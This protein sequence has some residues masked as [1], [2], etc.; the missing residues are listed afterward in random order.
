MRGYL[1][2][3]KL[4]SDRVIGVISKELDDN[5]LK[6]NG[7]DREAAQELFEE[8]LGDDSD[9]DALVHDIMDELRRRLILSTLELILTIQDGRLSGHLTAKIEQSS[10]NRLG[11]SQVIMPLSLA[12]FLHRLSMVSA[13]AVRFFPRLQSCSRNLFYW[14]VKVSDTRRTPRR[15]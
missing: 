6:L 15:A 14:M 11:G 8:R 9:F 10:S 7:A 1:D 12:D 5:V 3:I 2:R 4:I 13:F